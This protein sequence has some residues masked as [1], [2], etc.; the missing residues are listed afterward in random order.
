VQG[1]FFKN[2]LDGGAGGRAS[3]RVWAAPTKEVRSGAPQKPRLKSFNASR[4]VYAA[5]IEKSARRLQAEKSK[6]KSFW[7]L[8]NFYKNS[9]KEK[10]FGVQGDFYKNPP[11]GCGQRPRKRRCRRQSL[12]RN[13]SNT[14]R[15]YTKPYRL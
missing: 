3:C 2:P 5:S 13:K 9:P 15:R 6:D 14:L 7:G 1:D 4:R 12:L 10:V 8:G 11:D